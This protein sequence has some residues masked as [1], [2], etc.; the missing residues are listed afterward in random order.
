MK[1]LL[2][3]Y[4]A[5]LSAATLI[6]AGL[7]TVMTYAIDNEKVTYAQPTPGATVDLVPQIEDEPIAV[8]QIKLPD[9]PP[10]VQDEPMMPKPIPAVFKT[11]GIAGITNEAPSNQKVNPNPVGY[12][13]D[14]EHLPIMTV[15][16]EYPA[17][18]ARRGVEGWVIVEFIVDEL[19]RVQAPIVLE[20]QPARVFDNAALKAVLRYKYKPRVVNGRAIPV[21]GVRQRITF[22]L[23]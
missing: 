13:T 6:T 22:T 20:G 19:G 1:T 3:R 10:P 17:A 11:G 15:A 5:S 16:P 18:A 7:L 2:K 23:T 9:L 21:E 8:K 14:G 12:N 4:G